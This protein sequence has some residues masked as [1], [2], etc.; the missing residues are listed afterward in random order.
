MQETPKKSV[1]ADIDECRPEDAVEKI[2]I[3]GEA[4]GINNLDG[5]IREVRKLNLNDDEEIAD[6]LLE[7]A[8]KD[9]YISAGLDSEYR[10]SLLVEYNRKIHG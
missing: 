6:R 5:I 2:M 8:R 7:K 4:V 1:C 3:K 9:N 10:Y